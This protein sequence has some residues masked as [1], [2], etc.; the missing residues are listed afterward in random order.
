MIAEPADAFSQRE[1]LLSLAAVI[2]SSLGVGLAYGMGYPLTSLVLEQRGE[3]SWVIGIAGAVPFLAVLMLLPVLPRAV[4]RVNPITAI[5]AGC[6]LTVAGYGALYVL[7][8]T[9]AWIV[10][11]FLMGAALVLPWI[12]GETWINHMATDANRTRVMA[13]Y[14]TAIFSGYALGPIVLEAVGTTD[15]LPFLTGALGALFSAVPIVL[16]RRLVP[17]LA[18]EPH[19][20]LWGGLKMSP[21]AMAA[22]FLGGFLETTQVALFP[23]VAMAAG[24]DENEALR[25]LTILLV[26]GV[27]PQFAL[28]WIGDKT[29]RKGVLIASGIIYIVLIAMLPEALKSANLAHMTVFVTGA[30]VVGFYTLGLAVLGEEVA[31]RDLATANAAFILA[32][33]LGGMIG[34]AASGAAMTNAPVLGFV[35]S[36]AGATAIVTAATLMMRRGARQAPRA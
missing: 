29:S 25:L 34:P 8:S 32:Y 36:T 1:R 17:D 28:G 35:I 21:I 7:E 12:V 22:G 15:M 23:S 19:T 18:H 10:I 16:A 31:P 3:P 6:F 24:M 4:A 30:I 20:G 27:L 5:L 9:I 14:S 33:T 2:I 26:G 11:R 13:F